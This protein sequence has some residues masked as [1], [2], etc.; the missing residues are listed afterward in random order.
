MRIDKKAFYKPKMFQKVINST[1]QIL[2]E[3]FK[4][5]SWNDF[6]DDHTLDEKQVSSM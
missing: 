2:R 4:I 1:S 5:K 6:K 3:N